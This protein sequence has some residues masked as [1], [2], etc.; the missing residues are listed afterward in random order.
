M[1][2]GRPSMPFC[3]DCQ[4]WKKDWGIWAHNRWT[5]ECSDR[6]WCLQN[7]NLSPPLEMLGTSIICHFYIK[8]VDPPNVFYG[9]G[10]GTPTQ[11]GKHHG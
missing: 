4:H 11:A 9:Q 6:G 5:R 2:Y 7:P 1:W 10:V 8:K 3:E